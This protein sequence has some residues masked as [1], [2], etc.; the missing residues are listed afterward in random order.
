MLIVALMISLRQ[1]EDEE[2]DDE[3]IKL[4]ARKVAMFS[5][6]EDWI[7]RLSTIEW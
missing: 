1:H 5:L 2:M 4:E 7:C 6:L 3:L